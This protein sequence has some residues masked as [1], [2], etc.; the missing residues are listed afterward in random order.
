MMPVNPPATSASKITAGNQKRRRMCLRS[1][2][3]ALTIAVGR[4]DFK[5]LN[6]S[7][8]AIL[9]SF[10]DYFW[11]RIVALDTM[12]WMRI[13]GNVDCHSGPV[14]PYAAKRIISILRP[15]R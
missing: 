13:P 10:P 6:G 4:Y 11:R 2:G 1:P 14:L 8:A 5:R 3:G 9:I 12:L 15:E 7:L